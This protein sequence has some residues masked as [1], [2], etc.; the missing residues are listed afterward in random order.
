[1]INL[2][3][4]STGASVPRWA[5]NSCRCQRSGHLEEVSHSTMKLAFESADLKCRSGLRL[6][7]PYR[8]DLWSKNAPGRT[9]KPDPPQADPLLLPFL[10]A[11]T[12]AEEDRALQSLIEAVG[13]GIR[14]LIH[15]KLLLFEAPGFAAR[16]RATEEPARRAA[17][18]ARTEGISAE[19]DGAQKRA[20][21]A[22]FHRGT[23]TQNQELAIDLYHDAVARLLSALRKLKEA[24]P[25]NAG[26]TDVAGLD[27]ELYAR[28]PLHD[29]AGF[30]RVVVRNLLNE[31]LRE[32][33]PQRYQLQGRVTFVLKSPDPETG[34]CRFA[35]WKV[36]CPPRASITRVLRGVT[37][38]PTAPNQKWERIGGFAR[39][40]GQRPAHTRE[41]LEL[42][43]QPALFRS[44]F[45]DLD[46][47]STP[48]RTVLDALFGF[49]RTP[50]EFQDLVTCL[51]Q[52][53]G[54]VEPPPA[55]IDAD[56]GAE[57]HPGRE[58]PSRD[59]TPEMVLVARRSLQTVWSLIRAMPPHHAAALLLTPLGSNG[60]V[61]DVFPETGIATF[62][63]IAQV[64]GVPAPRL[65]A[66]W[67]A[68]G[69]REAGITAA[70]KRVKADELVADLLQ[71]NANVV[72]VWRF[73][74]RLRLQKEL[75]AIGESHLE[76]AERP[77]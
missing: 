2:P 44:S 70:S 9:G 48:L 4:A 60:W 17:H 13:P 51:A 28:T 30:T 34:A 72:G 42:R 74:A 1:M 45:S 71:V 58:L 43:N 40:C 53:L 20:A 6:G 29:L 23:V 41:W 7:V 55:E 27:G 18:Q 36:E 57:A 73:R 66:F 46:P 54:V 19:V 69:D 15:Q 35:L 24:A 62:S 16:A 21:H 52:I 64:I 63:E 3:A 61:I 39:W 75:N 38:K 77:I 31:H 33:Y 65:A 47:A 76:P 49:V 68:L 11:Q 5:P 8:M 12:E 26:P 59:P 67:C 10:A 37:G 56:S 50:V 25:R 22:Q 32:C 14:A